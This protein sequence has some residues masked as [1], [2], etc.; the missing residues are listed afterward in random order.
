M[1]VLSIFFKSYVDSFITW[2]GIVF[3]V[4]TLRGSRSG[5]RKSDTVV[6]LIVRSAIQTGCFAT[7]WAIADLVTWFFLPRVM[8]F[9]LFDL[10]SGSIYTHVSDYSSVQMTYLK[11]AYLR[12]SLTPFL[13]VSICVSRCYRQRSNSD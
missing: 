10:T 4:R 1:Y 9:R 6:N 13:H 5:I 8:A 11:E 2:A 12:Q 3:L 7:I